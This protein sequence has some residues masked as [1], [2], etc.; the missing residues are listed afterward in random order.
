MWGAGAG[1]A[2]AWGGAGGGVPRL[3]KQYQHWCLGGGS[4]NPHGDV[5]PVLGP[6]R[7]LVPLLLEM[8][9][10][11]RWPGDYHLN[12]S[13]NISP[14]LGVSCSGHRSTIVRTPARVRQVMDSIN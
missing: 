3:C 4:D 1:R 7:E 8:A 9:T 10:L 12:D 2:G 5:F 14:P 11:A 13:W 6:V